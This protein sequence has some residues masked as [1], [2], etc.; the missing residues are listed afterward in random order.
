[1]SRWGRDK[2]MPFKVKKVEDGWK[3]VNADSG[4]EYSKEAHKTAKE[5][6]A[7]LTAM[8]AN[9]ADETKD[10]SIDEA[11]Q[12]IRTKI[13]KAVNPPANQGLPTPV[14]SV[15]PEDHYWIRDIYA[16][17][18]ILSKN[19]S[20]YRVTL[21][22][23]FDTEEL[24]VGPIEPVEVQYV[25]VSHSLADGLKEL[26]KRMINAFKKK[27]I[28]AQPVSVF[29]DKD[30]NWRWVLLSSNAYR[31]LDG[32]IVSMK[33]IQKD[34]DLGDRMKEK[35]EIKDYGPLRWW[36]VKGADIGDCDFRMLQGRVLIES[37]TFRD[38]NIGAAV[39]HKAKDLQVSIGFNHP[40]SEP[41]SDGV[42][43]TIKTFERSLVPSGRVAN[44]LT[45]VFA[46]KGVDMTTLKE[47]LEAFSALVKDDELVK[48]ILGQA[49]TVEKEAD[50]DGIA[51]KAKKDEAAAEDETDIEDEEVEEDD[52]SETSGKEL[53]NEYY[54]SDMSVK[55]FGEMLAEIMTEAL[56]PA[57]KEMQRPVAVDATT[58]KDAKVAELT[59]KVEELTLKLKEA[60]EAPKPR[61][62]SASTDNSTVVSDQEKVKE[63]GPKSDPMEFIT[64]FVGVGG[65]PAQ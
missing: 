50:A 54:L 12:R 13:D 41:D 31:D 62:F 18:A 34:I 56:V 57:L 55:E 21:T 7:Q 46:K 19:G 45:A 2:K 11:T 28:D 61:A 64:A 14:G 35:G 51:F 36:H 22:H 30:G 29:K 26:G 44:P 33:A 16:G 38:Q 6:Y 27:E 59:K 17:Y 15:Y 9:G 49:Q 3:V 20:L 32:E 48:N 25:P 8:E 52:D 40:F 5:A 42:F 24:V 65:Q 1:M 37:G 53:D 60:T 39:A 47:K 63:L 58:E 4:K 23:D 43:H 10:I